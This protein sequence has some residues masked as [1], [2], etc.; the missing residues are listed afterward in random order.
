MLKL[1]KAK[2][3]FCRVDTTT[4]PSDAG[5]LCGV[6]EWRSGIGAF[7][8]RFLS[9]DDD[10]SGQ[11]TYYVEPLMRAVMSDQTTDFLNR[12]CLMGQKVLT[13]FDPTTADSPDQF[14]LLHT[15]FCHRNEGHVAVGRQFKRPLDFV[16]F[17][18]NGPCRL[19]VP[20]LGEETLAS[21]NQT[22]SSCASQI[23]R[24]A[25][26]DAG[27]PPG[28]T[29]TGKEALLNLLEPW[30]MGQSKVGAGQPVCFPWNQQC[31][32]SDFDLV[33]TDGLFRSSSWD[34]SAA[35]SEF[36]RL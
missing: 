11:R 28:E 8:I 32:R 4:D 3:S 26:T 9:P 27:S 29:T 10:P 33:M 12:A 20:G 13:E 5:K 35:A 15:L 36:A 16:D 23:F 19:I 17:H 1:V 7:T 14:K 21:E 30:F 25:L 2:G 34:S 22:I 18:R 6:Y 31:G 24:K